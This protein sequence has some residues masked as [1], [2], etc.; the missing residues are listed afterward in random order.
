MLWWALPLVIVSTFLVGTL[1]GYGTH[2]AIHSPLAKLP[3]FKSLARAHMVHHRLYP[4]QDF[5]SD[6]YR[7]AQEND[8]TF[9]FLPI[10]LLSVVLL[11][12]GLW[13]L[14]QSFWIFPVIMIEGVVVGYA[15]E[16]VH[17]IFHVR[18]HPWNKFRMFRKLKKLHQ[19]HHQ[20]PKYNQGIIWLG[21]D[22]IFKTF[23]G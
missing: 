22:R 1:V 16:K 4:I 12:G 21:L 11:A 13:L 9:F 7:S 15:N 14:I 20:S 2:R 17:G 23:K 5:E 8:S 3:G 19:I 18:N 6:T 10:I